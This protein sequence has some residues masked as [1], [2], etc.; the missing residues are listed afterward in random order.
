MI[1]DKCY[2]EGDQEWR[3]AGGR[4]DEWEKGWKKNKTAWDDRELRCMSE[5]YLA[6]SSDM[7]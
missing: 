5:K 6:R 4:E 2:V 1:N 3:G 7:R